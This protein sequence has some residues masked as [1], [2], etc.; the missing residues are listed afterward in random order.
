MSAGHGRRRKKHEEHEEHENHERWL[1]SGFDM[2]TLLFVLFVVLYAMSK[3]DEQKFAAL[4]KGMAEAFGG[5]V[6]VQPAPT[7]DGSVLDG[8]PGVIDIASA[9]PP[10]PTVEQAQIDKAAA[11]AAVQRAENIAAEAEEAYDELAAA[12][13]KIEAA[14]TAAGYAGAARY[15][16][17][18]RGLVVHIVADQVLFDAEE[19]VLRPEGREI[20]AAV[21]PAVTELPNAIGVEGHANHLPVSR[22][23]PWPS[24]WELSATRATTVVRYLASEGVPEPRLT[25][26]GYS[27]TRPLVPVSD[28][29]A[30]TVNRRVDVVVLSDA[31]AEANALL[32]DIDAAHQGGNR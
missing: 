14:L 28:P 13:D 8:L 11:A 25:A 15:E 7:P 4:A 23:G 10:D 5:P 9:I 31:S 1:V 30:L 16:I 22:G 19:A 21:A 12:R 2:M 20:L 18:E 29:N 27:S 17:D 26:V 32:P 6:T 24:N 3:V